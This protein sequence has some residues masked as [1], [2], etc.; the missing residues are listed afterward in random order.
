MTCAHLKLLGP[1]FK[2]GQMGD[3]LDTECEIEQS[4][5]HN[6]IT[7]TKCMHRAQATRLPA[8]SHE[9]TNLSLCN[10]AH[11]PSDRP[12]F[13][14]KSWSSFRPSNGV[15]G[16]FGALCTQVHSPP[17]TPTPVQDFAEPETS[18]MRRET[19]E[20]ARDTSAPSA[21][22]ITVS[23]SLA[24]SFQSAFQLSFTVLVCYRSRSHI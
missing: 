13:Q 20:Y 8:T 16:R 6:L 23:R 2:T 11:P 18:A 1:C 3:R 21:S 4:A 5:A 10:Q 9:F 17:D 7:R 12:G 14:L 15:L 22:T 19:A 24:L